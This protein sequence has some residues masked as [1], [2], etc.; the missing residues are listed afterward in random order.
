M[1]AKKIV[2]DCDEKPLLSH[3]PAA[4]PP[5]HQKNE[6]YD[7]KVDAE[8]E[9]I[10][11]SPELDIAVEEAVFLRALSTFNSQGRPYFKGTSNT[12]SSSTTR[13]VY[14]ENLPELTTRPQCYDSPPSLCSSSATSSSSRSSLSSFS[15]KVRFAEKLVTEVRLRPKTPPDEREALFYTFDEIQR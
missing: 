5:S 1:T 8:E 7:T 15:R 13:R 12:T 3:S 9:W 2:V 4:I 6:E 11:Y 14:V 10:L